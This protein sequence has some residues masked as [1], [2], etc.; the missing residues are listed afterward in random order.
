MLFWCVSTGLSAGFSGEYLGCLS[1][2]R[3]QRTQRGS[4]PFSPLGVSRREPP[5]DRSVRRSRPGQCQVFLYAFNDAGEVL[6]GLLKRG[7]NNDGKRNMSSPILR[8]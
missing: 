3:T 2:L 7:G 6:Q 1:T 8:Q 4:L 5:L